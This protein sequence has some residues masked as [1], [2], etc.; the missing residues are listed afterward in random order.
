MASEVYTYIPNLIG[1]TRMIFAVIAFA[2][3]H[4]NFI[5]FYIF[6]SLSALL[7]MADGHAARLFNQCSKFG[8]VLDMVTD[9]ASTACLIV[10]LSSFYPRYQSWFLFLIALDMVSHFA[11]IYSSLSQGHSHKITNKNMN[12]FLKIYYDNKYV[13]AFL[14]FG[15]EGFFVLLHTLHFW[16]GPALPLGP[17]GFV[18][19]YFG[20]VNGT[21]PFVACWCFLVMM[22]IMLIKQTMNVIQLQQAAI[23]IVAMDDAERKTK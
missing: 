18:A 17:L 20:G 9:R 13:L 8:A 2:F 16:Q 10:V 12:P 21:L 23:D 11:H 1:Y 15:N 4:D 7:D 6:Y 14:C 5:V 19:P 22:P 3:A